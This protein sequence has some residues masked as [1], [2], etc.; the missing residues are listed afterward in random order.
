MYLKF[1]L[2]NIDEHYHKHSHNFIVTALLVELKIRQTSKNKYQLIYPQPNLVFA[3]LSVT[4]LTAIRHE[5]I[6]I[7]WFNM[8][9][10][11]QT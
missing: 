5:I 7:T 1:F 11:L 9:S 4:V 10:G 6:S 2:K 8:F 3:I